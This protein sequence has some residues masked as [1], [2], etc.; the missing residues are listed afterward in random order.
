[1]SHV[2][3]VVWLDHRE[4]KVVDFSVDEKH[5]VNVH[6]KGGHRQVH[7]KAGSPGSGHSAD[8]GQFYDAIVAA[9][10]DAQEV[11]VTGPGN[12]KVAFRDHVAKRH[13]ALAK[14][15]VGVETLDHPSEGELL[16]YAR[17]YFKRVDN[18]LG[19]R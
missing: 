8:D 7:H 2:H 3:A 12:A 10:D 1:M 11:L 13:A 16:A 18:M 15:V 6:H 9:L 5:V 4:A 14:R 19:D 17:R